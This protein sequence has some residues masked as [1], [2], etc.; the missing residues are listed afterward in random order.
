MKA[1]N[2]SRVSR[3]K[4]DVS[5]IIWDDVIDKINY[6]VQMQEFSVIHDKP[7]KHN[8]LAKTKERI[9]LNTPP[10]TIIC[11]GSYAPYSFKPIVDQ[12]KLYGM[13]QFHTYVS[14][15]KGSSTFGRHNDIDNVMICPIV[16]KIG[17]TV[18]ELGRVELDPGDVLYIP[19]YVYHEPHVY[20]PRAI[21]SFSGAADGNV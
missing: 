12:F 6:D 10:P 15:C 11:E 1:A 19:R 8:V 5:N 18:D 2:G 17:Y 21:L 3:R 13:D 7:Q 4:V 9:L 20:G 16:G 14:F